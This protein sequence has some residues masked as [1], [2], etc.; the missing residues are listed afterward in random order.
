MVLAAAVVV[1]VMLVVVVSDH[2]LYTQPASA[3]IWALLSSPAWTVE[4]PTMVVT[5]SCVT[6]PMA[7]VKTAELVAAGT[8]APTAI[9]VSGAR[10]LAP[11]AAGAAWPPRAGFVVSGK[12]AN[13]V[14]ALIDRC[15]CGTGRTGTSPRAREATNESTRATVMDFRGISMLG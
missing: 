11:P 14:A 1:V 15:N 13:E 6:A 9:T 4:A 8:T 3:L 7:A 10:L 2:S 5:H 12:C